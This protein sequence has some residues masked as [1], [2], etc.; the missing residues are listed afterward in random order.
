MSDR[1]TEVKTP[2]VL[3]TLSPITTPQLRSSRSTQDSQYDTR[4]E[5]VARLPE[6]AT[7]SHFIV[8]NEPLTSRV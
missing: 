4:V 5:K 8:S 3:K 6:I 2:Y 1:H 7:C